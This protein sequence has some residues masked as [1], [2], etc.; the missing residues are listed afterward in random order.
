MAL[1][2][3]APAHKI[4]PVMASGR[5][6]DENRA[7]GKNAGNGARTRCE[8]CERRCLIP[9]GGTGFCK[10]RRN[11]GGKIRLLTYGRFTSCNVDPIEKKPFNHFWPGSSTLSLGSV[12]C[13]FRCAG[14]QNWQIACPEDPLSI[15]MLELTPQQAVDI[16]KRAEADGISFTYNEPV[17]WVEFILD[18]CELARRDGLYTNMVTNG[19]MTEKTLNSLNGRLDAVRIDV[20]GTQECY[21]S[22]TKGVDAKLIRRNAE[23]A[24]KLGMHLEIITNLIPGLVDREEV[25]RDIAKW[26]KRDLGFET[27][28]HLTRFHP[29]RNLTDLPAT[30]LESLERAVDIGRQEGLAYVYLGNY[31]GHRNESTWCP[32]CAALLIKRSILGVEELNLAGGK[33]PKC[34]WTV[35]I[36][37]KARLTKGGPFGPLRG[38]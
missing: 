37:G 32:G 21:D 14:C 2:L 13:N 4:K 19:Y 20:K 12:G 6:E 1:S 22:I 3:Y 28:W 23:R 34:G 38:C 33:C 29:A 26:I 9:D 8:V 31:P 7:A 17:I 10:I 36:A 16:A 15:P 11:E 25:L 5:R 35:P 18:C 30:S 24:C 27:P